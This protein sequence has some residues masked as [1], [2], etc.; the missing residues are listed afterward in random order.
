MSLLDYI[1]SFSKKA[2]NNSN[3]PAI[4]LNSELQNQLNERGFIKIKLLDE[5]TVK[6]L[7]N[8]F[9]SRPN[10]K[11]EKFGFHVTLDLK[12]SAEIDEISNF[13]KNTIQP[14]ADAFF[15][16]YKFI[17]PRFAVKEPNENSLIPPHQDWSFVDEEH[18]QSYNLWIAITPSTFRNGTLGFLPGSHNKLTNIRATPL[19]L[20]KVP[21]NDYAYELTE[22]LEFI[23]LEEG[24]AFFFNNRL[25]HASK[26]NTT[27]EARINIAI[28]T[29]HKEAALLHYNLSPDNKTI[30]EYQIDESFFTKYSNAKLTE[31]YSKKIHISD[32]PMIRKHRYHREVI[33]KK[34]LIG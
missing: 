28:E 8:F 6:D 12:S 21:F 18:F 29:T 13:I 14:F 26:P 5:T 30:L 20:F 1:K 33:N 25:I 31:M 11:N 4:L 15:K 7:L 27:S 16:D 3:Y 10:P 34:K 32:Y 9:R 2:L 24:E 23:E 22:S 17:S 19:P